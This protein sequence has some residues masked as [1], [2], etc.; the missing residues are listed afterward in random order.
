MSSRW[1]NCSPAC[2]WTQGSP[3]QTPRGEGILAIKIHST[4]S[5]GGKI[6]PSVPYYTILRYV[7]IACNYEQIYFEGQIYHFTRSSSDL[8][9]DGSIGRNAS[10]QWWTNQELPCRY[11]STMVLNVH[12]SPGRWIGPLVATVP[13]RSLTPMTSPSPPPPSCHLSIHSDFL[14]CKSSNECLIKAG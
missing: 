6:K 13:R 12:I 5:F 11:H 7:E 2:H 14:L 9:L 4:P 10:E 3:V 1:W 8:L